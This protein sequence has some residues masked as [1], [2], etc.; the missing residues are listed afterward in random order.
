MGRKHPQW[1]QVLTIRVEK[2]SF[3]STASP[4]SLCRG[5]P[6]SASSLP[7]AWAPGWSTILPYGPSSPEGM[8]WSL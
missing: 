4:G 6:R 8:E 7:I 1:T 5:L 2:E 3:S